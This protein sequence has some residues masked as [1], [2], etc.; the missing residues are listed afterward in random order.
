MK[1]KATSVGTSKRI[2]VFNN[3]VNSVKKDILFV[4]VGTNV[5][6]SRQ[7]QTGIKKLKSLIPCALATN[8]SEQCEQWLKEY[9]GDENILLIVSND[10]GMQIMPHIHSLSSIV[11]VYTYGTNRRGNSEWIKNYPKVRNVVP[12]ITQLVETISM[13]LKDVNQHEN[14]NVECIHQQSTRN[15]TDQCNQKQ[16]LKRNKENTKSITNFQFF[17]IDVTKNLNEHACAM[18]KVLISMTPTAIHIFDHCSSI[19]YR[20][21]PNKPTFLLV[22]SVFAATMNDK[23]KQVEGILILE[24]NGNPVDHRTH[25]ENGEDLIFELADEIY[26]CYIKEANQ[27]SQS[28]GSM[29]AEI[30]KEQ[31]NQVHKNIKEAY[32]LVFNNHD[33]IQSW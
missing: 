3:K 4:W 19:D 26:R 8:D 1:R 5:E 30:K 7:I 28:G 15:F 22:S 32:K 29:I 24:E 10:L 23:P 31:A 9:I 11:V 16:T 33:S 12:N 13:D 27:Y 18:L 17:L 20:Q 2:K 14:M 25:F 21:L 6:E